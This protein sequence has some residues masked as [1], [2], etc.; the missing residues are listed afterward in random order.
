MDNTSNKF[1]LSHDWFHWAPEL[2][3]SLM[4]MMPKRERFIEIGSYEG[5]ST[6]WTVENMLIDGSSILCVDTWAGGEEHKPMG[7]DMDCVESRFN[8]NISLLAE[9]HPQ[10]KVTKVKST[11]YEAIAKYAARAGDKFD[12]AYIDGSHIA[13]DVLT[14]ACMLWPLINSGGIVVFDD[15]VWGE[16]RDVLHRPKLAVDTFTTLFS[17]ELRIVH[18]GYQLVAQKTGE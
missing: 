18:S 16:P 9:R 4:P 1:S 8:Y 12:F 15:Y 3:T 10:R 6:I 5:R 17:E 13:R 11:S 14:D 2:W 7:E